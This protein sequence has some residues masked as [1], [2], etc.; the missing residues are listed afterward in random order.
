VLATWDIRSQKTTNFWTDVPSSQ[1]SYKSSADIAFISANTKEFAIGD[2]LSLQQALLD[3]IASLGVAVHYFPSLENFLKSHASTIEHI[4]IAW[5]EQRIDHTVLDEFLYEH[6]KIYQARYYTVEEPGKQ[7]TYTPASDPEECSILQAHLQDFGIWTFSN[8]QQE[9]TLY[10]EVVV[11]A[12]VEC[13]QR[14]YDYLAPYIGR[15]ETLCYP[16]V[17]ECKYVARMF[18]DISARIDGDQI[19]FLDVEDVY[20]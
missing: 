1:H 3:D 4:T 18:V 17:D 10:F 20:D 16:I 7:S 9:I 6:N 12:F 19:I 2:P 13:I 14:D 15:D 5:I 8:Q 11:E